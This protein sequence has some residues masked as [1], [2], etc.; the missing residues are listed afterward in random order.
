VDFVDLV[1]EVD[2]V[3]VVDAVHPVHYD[4]H[5]VHHVHYVHPAADFMCKAAGLLRPGVTARATSHSQLANRN[6]QLQP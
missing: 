5:P 6:D 3:D 2:F 1:D 4:V